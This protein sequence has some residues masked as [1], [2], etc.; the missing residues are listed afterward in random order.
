MRAGTEQKAFLEELSSRS[1]ML[2]VH[3]LINLAFL[4]V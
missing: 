1:M 2:Q 3:L 4:E